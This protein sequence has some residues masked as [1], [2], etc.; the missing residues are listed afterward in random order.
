MNKHPFYG[1]LYIVLFP[2]GLLIGFSVVVSLIAALQN[3][4]VL[5]PLFLMACM[6]I[7]TITSFI[8]YVKAVG[9]GQQC[10]PSLRDWI[11]VNAIVSGI[12]TA[13]LLLESVAVVADPSLVNLGLEK[14]KEMQ[15]QLPMAEGQ[16]A[17]YILYM[18]YAILVYSLAMVIHIIYT[19]A[20][21][22]KYKN[23]FLPDDRSLDSFGENV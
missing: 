19:F 3:P 7:Y 13:I 4:T 14:L 2:F 16:L 10:K 12:V 6:V 1:L 23:Y 17:R 18:F 8:F 22:S 5:I 15:Q 9:Q 20:L 11:R 21:L